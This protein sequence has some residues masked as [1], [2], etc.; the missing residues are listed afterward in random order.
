MNT[1]IMLIVFSLISVFVDIASA[2]WFAGGC[3]LGMLLF[4][5][6]IALDPTAAIEKIHNYRHR[7]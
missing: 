3:L 6:R 7:R 5:L 4:A 2:G 1:L